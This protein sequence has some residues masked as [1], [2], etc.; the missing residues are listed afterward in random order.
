MC[1]VNTNK[2]DQHTQYAVQ[3]LILLI[4]WN[5]YKSTFTS[6]STRVELTSAAGTIWVLSVIQLGTWTLRGEAPTSQNWEGSDQEK[7]NGK[8][9]HVEPATR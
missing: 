4:L 1:F 3:T 7:D 9:H 2:I 5:I 6:S 8:L